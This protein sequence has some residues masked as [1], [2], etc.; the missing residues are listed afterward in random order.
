MKIGLSVIKLTAS[1]LIRF[2]PC[3]SLFFH[4]YNK[5]TTKHGTEALAD[6]RLLAVYFLAD[7]K[8]PTEAAWAF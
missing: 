3:T 4:W 7:I 6:Q 8:L 5:T 2:L 1:R